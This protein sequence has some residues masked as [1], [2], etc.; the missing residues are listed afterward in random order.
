MALTYY[1]SAGE[2]LLCRYDIVVVEPEMCKPRPV[3]VIGPR[4]RSRSRL[5]AVVPLSTTEPDVPQAYH[6]LIEL[7]QSLPRPFDKPAMWAKCDMV[8]SVSLARLDRFKEPYHRG[9]GRQWRAGRTTNEQLQQ[10]RV[11]MLCG[12][13][14]ATLTNY[15]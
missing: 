4:L 15:L 9:G 12:L 13:G 7:T 14:F 1:P 10:I 11:G 3:V 5:V 8:S 2:I 6:V